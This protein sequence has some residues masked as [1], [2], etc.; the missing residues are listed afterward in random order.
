MCGRY[1]QTSAYAE[2]AELFGLVPKSTNSCPV[3]NGAARGPQEIIIAPGMVAPVLRA[4]GFT[5]MR[6]GFTP[7]WSKTDSGTDI[8]NARSETLLEKPSFKKAFL[9]QR[10]LVPA[11]GFYEWDKSRK[12]SLPYDIHFENNASFAFAA[13]WDQWKDRK[14][15]E[16]K[17]TFALVTRAAT[18]AVA[19]VHARMPVIF[20]N[21][22]EM[23]KWLD[24]TTPLPVVEQM[25]NNPPENLILTPVPRL[26]KAHLPEDSHQLALFR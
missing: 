4:H 8:I 19:A 12:P 18:S 20:R 2:L 11:N 15:G 5:D 3:P 6:W 9:Q 10:C 1:K 24:I 21:I 7:G 14:T 22:N 17:E 13:I 25:F 26:T 23:K 16:V